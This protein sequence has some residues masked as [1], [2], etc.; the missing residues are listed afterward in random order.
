MPLYTAQCHVCGEKQ[1]YMKRVDDRY[2]TPDCCG[3]QTTK[4]IDLVEVGAMVFTE[5]KG[6]HMP[7][8]KHGGKGTFIGSGQEY[9]KYLKDNNKMPSHEAHAEAERQRKYKTEAADKKRRE[10]VIKVVK[11]MTD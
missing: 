10:D 8:G 1:T 11:R 3:V 9:K 4:A 5:H 2:D 7:D 6:F